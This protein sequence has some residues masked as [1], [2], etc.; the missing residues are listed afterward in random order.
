VAEIITRRIGAILRE[1]QAEAEVGR[2]VQARDETVDH[3]LRDE[4][5]A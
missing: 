3:R 1:L 5:E 4:V 2:A